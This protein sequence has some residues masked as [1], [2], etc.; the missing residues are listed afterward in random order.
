MRR[1]LVLPA[2]GT[3]IVSTDMHG[4]GGDFRRLRELFLAEG[5]DAHWVILGDIV[6][7][8]SDDART[9]DPAL[10][11]YD[12]ESGAIAIGIREL[13]PCGRVHFVIGNHDYGHIG[14]P[15][16]SK[17]H[18]DEVAHL[19]SRLSR[20]ERQA[21]DAL[22]REALIAVVAPCGALLTHGSPD[23][24][25]RA[26]SDLDA[27]ALPPAPGDDYGVGILRSFLYCYGQRRDVTE[28]LLATVSRAGVRVTMVIH[29]H[30]RDPKGWFVEGDNQVCVV[31]FGATREEKRYVQLDLSARYTDARALRDGHEI[32]RL[33]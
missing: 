21:L 14:G 32:R 5:P 3:L 25:L 20:T 9:S 24:S 31:L 30:D 19:D 33:Y 10:Y 8:P 28:R 23:D 27:I 11:D 7:A 13:L 1:H 4:N 26:L 6:H 29:G 22:C 16:S 17:F 15:H 18:P 12:D 2:S